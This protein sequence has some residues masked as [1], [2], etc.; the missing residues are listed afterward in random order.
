[1]RQ[2]EKERAKR[3]PAPPATATPATT[4]ATPAAASHHPA[5]A[6][7]AAALRA[8]AAEHVAAMAVLAERRTVDLPRQLLAV[9]GAVAVVAITPA[10]WAWRHECVFMC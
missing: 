10:G 3:R 8:A 9:F 2:F 6:A 7:A 5:L 1:M 4:T